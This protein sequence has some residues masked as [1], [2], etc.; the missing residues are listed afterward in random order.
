MI[1]LKDGDWK[2]KREGIASLLELVS[3]ER[4][5]RGDNMC[6]L[7]SQIK[8]GLEQNNKNIQKLYIQLC[9]KVVLCQEA[10]E[11]AKH[12]KAIVLMLLSTLS[13]KSPAIR[14]D[15]LSS[16]KQ[17]GAYLGY[18]HI[19]QQGILLMQSATPDFRLEFL[20]LLHFIN[21]ISSSSLKFIDFKHAALP[22]L[23][24]LIDKNQHVRSLTEK[25]LL[26]IFATDYQ[27]LIQIFY[28]K[29]KLFKQAHQNEIHLILHSINTN[30]TPI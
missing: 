21:T 20:T 3:G 18:E 30:T 11:V 6:E 27:N 28:E 23:N 24:C 1:Q 17:I 7:Y 5:K 14:Q 10:K 22:L 9:C 19:L 15:L 25:Y 29:I 4:K 8:I 26:F 16:L 12:L 2:V 13:H